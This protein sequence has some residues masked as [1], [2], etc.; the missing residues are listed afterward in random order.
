MLA[1]KTLNIGIKFVTFNNENN[2]HLKN[3]SLEE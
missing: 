2:K 3:D 1:F